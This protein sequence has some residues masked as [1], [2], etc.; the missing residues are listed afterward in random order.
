VKVNLKEIII[1]LG[2]MLFINQVSLVN[3]DI[4]LI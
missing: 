2:D 4:L 3:C 1:F